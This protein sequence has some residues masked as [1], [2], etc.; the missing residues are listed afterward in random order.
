MPDGNFFRFTIIPR[1]RVNYDLLPLRT[2]EN[3]IFEAAG[4]SKI[5]VISNV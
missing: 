4:K 1:R 2:H 5:L 3:I